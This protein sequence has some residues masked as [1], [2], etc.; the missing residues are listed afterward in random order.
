MSGYFFG[1]D[2]ASVKTERPDYENEPGPKRLI[3]SPPPSPKESFFRPGS[4]PVPPGME[5]MYRD[6]PGKAT[7]NDVNVNVTFKREERKKDDDTDKNKKMM[8]H[9]TKHID[10]NR[11]LYFVK[12][13]AGALKRRHFQT[14]IEVEEE[15]ERPPHPL[16]SSSTLNV[17]VKYGY[18]YELLHAWTTVI[19]KIKRMLNPSVLLSNPNWSSSEKIHT[20]MIENDTA[21]TA[22]ARYVAYVM[23]SETNNFI[24]RNRTRYVLEMDQQ[25]EGQRVYD[26]MR[27]L[28]SEFHVLNPQIAEKY[29]I[30]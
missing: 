2:G 10:G 4:V 24:P 1:D 3:P 11:D 15:H 5:E 28:H 27:A 7:S 23:M 20:R 21:V 8:Y 18:A 25:V 30:I 12:L 19:E 14:L 17:Y 6:A 22:F 16:A 13:V 9:V 29:G 26:V